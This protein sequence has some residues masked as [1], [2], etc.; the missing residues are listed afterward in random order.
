VN[1]GGYI[2]FYNPAS[3]EHGTFPIRGDQVV[4]ERSPRQVDLRANLVIPA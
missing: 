3:G 4:E 1:P 2:G